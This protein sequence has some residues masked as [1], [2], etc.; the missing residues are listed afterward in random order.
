LKPTK[1][2]EIYSFNSYVV[3]T[4]RGSDGNLCGIEVQLRGGSQSSPLKDSQPVYFNIVDA[5]NLRNTI[6]AILFDNVN[7]LEGVRLTATEVS[8]QSIDE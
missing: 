6:S 7:S 8:G 3:K 5:L 2:E 4:Q 1:T